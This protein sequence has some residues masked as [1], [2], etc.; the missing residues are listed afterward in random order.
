M[1][2]GV[3]KSFR[4]WRGRLAVRFTAFLA[5]LILIF[6]VEFVCYNMVQS[7]FAIREELDR[8]VSYLGRFGADLTAQ[9]L[10]DLRLR[11][12]LATMRNF[13]SRSDIVYARLLDQYRRVVTD[14]VG[15]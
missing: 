13:S 1:G 3:I 6:S 9:D 15:T 2:M 12:L 5:A 4:R 8:H 7:N 10:K 14:G 11:E